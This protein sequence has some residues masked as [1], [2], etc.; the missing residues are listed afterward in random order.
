MVKKIEELKLNNNLKEILEYNL[1]EC[2]I[3]LES[4]G[5]RG[6]IKEISYKKVMV[7]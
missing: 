6:K 1:F 4:Q 7:S 3:F 5:K 2:I